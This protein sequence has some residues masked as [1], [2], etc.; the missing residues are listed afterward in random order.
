VIDAGLKDMQ[1]S[2]GYLQWLASK[3]LE[4]ILESPACRTRIMDIREIP[5]PPGDISPRLRSL[6]GVFNLAQ[7]YNGIRE[8][9]PSG[10]KR[11]E[12]MEEVVATMVVSKFDF[13]DG[14]LENALQAKDGGYRLWG[15]VGSGLQGKRGS[16]G[17]IIE[18]L[19][20]EPQNF[21]M[22]HGLQA[23][24]R[25]IAKVRT[26]PAG[27]RNDLLKAGER[28]PQSGERRV[29]FE[30]ILQRFPPATA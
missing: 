27:F 6:I 28:L 30:R 13:P 19:Q 22:Y 29:L 1:A 12:R 17:P 5:L 8:S 7:Q 18:A 15:Y 20:R 25:L 9:L 16:I 23:L 4:Q 3:V 11:T 2:T 21:C 10:A 14:L 24:E 26:I